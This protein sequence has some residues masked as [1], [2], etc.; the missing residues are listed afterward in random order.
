MQIISSLLSLQAKQ[1]RDKQ[2]VDKL[3]DSKNRIKSMTLVHEKLYESKDMANINFMITLT[4][5]Q[6]N[7]SLLM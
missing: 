7:S 4:A 5:L 2:Y 3:N 6:R 1:I